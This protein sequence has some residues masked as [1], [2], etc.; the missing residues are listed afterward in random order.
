MPRLVIEDWSSAHSAREKKMAHDRSR[1]DFFCG[2]YWYVFFYCRVRRRGFFHRR[3][4]NNLFYR[5]FC[6]DLFLKLMKRSGSECVIAGEHSQNSANSH[7]LSM[8][9][10]PGFPIHDAA[11]GS[12]EVVAGGRYWVSEV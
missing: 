11:T 7:F 10:E 5:G 3:L 6:Y 2:R 4:P 9:A 12:L 8:Q 1:Y